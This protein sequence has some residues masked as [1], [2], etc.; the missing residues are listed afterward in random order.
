MHVLVRGYNHKWT[1][2]NA[3]LIEFKNSGIAVY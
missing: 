1:D 3:T 2:C